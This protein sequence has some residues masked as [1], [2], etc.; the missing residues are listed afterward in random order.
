MKVKFLKDHQGWE[1]GNR[2]FRAGDVGDVTD[3]GAFALAAEGW[4]EPYDGAD[5]PAAEPVVEAEA[6][7]EIKEAVEAE[8][9]EEVEAAPEP[10]DE[11]EPVK[12][13]RRK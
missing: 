3:D 2:W 6:V 13:P 4:A 1:T 10:E 5:E 9:V 12:A 8:P 11:E 7:I